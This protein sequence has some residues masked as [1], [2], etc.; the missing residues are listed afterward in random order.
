MRY[1]CFGLKEWET[2]FS[3]GACLHNIFGGGDDTRTVW[4][5]Y[6]V[7][8]YNFIFYDVNGSSRIGTSFVIIIIVEA[9]KLIGCCDWNGRCCYCCDTI[10]WR[11]TSSLSYFDP[12]WI[13]DVGAQ[14]RG[15]ISIN[16]CYSI[17][18][19]FYI[20]LAPPPTISWSDKPT[21]TG[22]HSFAIRPFDWCRWLYPDD[23]ET[24]FGINNYGELD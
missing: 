2:E 1:F 21:L 19:F 3:S 12:C 7:V 9:S 18:Q 11:R 14:G 17:S 10:R 15:S 24:Y 4:C 20:T 16:F 13:R 5:Y 6:F 8:Q 22:V 23:L